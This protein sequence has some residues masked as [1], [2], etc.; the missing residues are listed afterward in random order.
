VYIGDVYSIDFLGARAAGMWAILMDPYGTYAG[1]GLPRITRLDE[2]GSVLEQI[3][4]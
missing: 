3:A 2:L 4:D 1:N